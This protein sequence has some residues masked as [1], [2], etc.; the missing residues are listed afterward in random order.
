MRRERTKQTL[1]LRLLAFVLALALIWYSL[2]PVPRTTI[3]LKSEEKS[4]DEKKRNV[5]PRSMP[6]TL[7]LAFRPLR[8]IAEPSQP[9][10]E[11][12]DDFEW[13]EYIDG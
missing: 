3:S 10:N 1:K 5:E 2:N 6:A 9:A 13:P 11:D 7:P 12:E 4:P 8:E